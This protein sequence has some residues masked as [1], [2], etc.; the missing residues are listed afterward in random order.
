MCLSQS[1]TQ[2]LPV[3]QSL[4][5]SLPVCQWLS[6]Y[7]CLRNSPKTDLVHPVHVSSK[8]FDA[9]IVWKGSCASRRIAARRGVSWRVAAHAGAM[10]A[11]AHRMPAFSIVCSS[12][13]SIQC[14]LFSFWFSFS[15]VSGTLTLLVCRY[16][17][18]YEL[19]QARRPCWSADTG[20]VMNCF[21]NI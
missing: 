11:S 6:F 14:T 7:L 4:C 10:D 12:R 18:G 19:F 17:P 3:I 1:V 16:W 2:S 8:A 20:G 9:V 5:V 13:R 21:I 15:L